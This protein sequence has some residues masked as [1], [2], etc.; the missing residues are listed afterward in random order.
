MP[1]TNDWTN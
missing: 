1:N